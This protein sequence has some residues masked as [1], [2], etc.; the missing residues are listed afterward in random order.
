[1]SRRVA[2]FMAIIVANLWG[3]G[4]ATHKY[5]GSQTFEVW[6]DYDPEFYSALLRNDSVGVM[7]RK[8]YYI[9]L[10][11]PDLIDTNAQKAMQAL[12]THLYED[13]PG[14]TTVVI[15]YTVQK[16]IL[17][18]WIRIPLR[19]TASVHMN[20]FS[21]LRI[22]EATYNQVQQL[23]YFN[24]DFPNT[25]LTKLREMVEFAKSQGWSPVDKALIY[26]AY[27]HVIHDLYAHMVLQPALFGY[28]YVVE[29]DSVVDKGLLYFPELYYEL[30]TDTY[31]PDWSFMEDLYAGYSFFDD[32]SANGFYFSFPYSF[33]TI[34]CGDWIGYT[35]Y[36]PGLR[37]AI[38]VTRVD[39]SEQRE[40]VEFNLRF[41]DS[42]TP[43]EP[44]GQ[45]TWL[46]SQTLIFSA[47]N[48]EASHV[49]LWKINI[50]GTGFEQVTY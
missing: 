48:P 30:F 18:V 46:D 17:G 24:G 5:I 25:N 42:W 29:S 49:V 40:L 16:E 36:G 11:L 21:P 33:Y 2:I 32:P 20:I 41:D 8:F 31:I 9:G 6:Q 15:D 44:G 12:I 34:K 38:C 23:M 50:D 19:I 3:H 13:L 39:G 1:M 26:G 37:M 27:M 28:P 4:L 22:Q 10:V 35:V 47:P 7:T 43:A 45:V 14:D